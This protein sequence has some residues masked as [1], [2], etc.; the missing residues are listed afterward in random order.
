MGQ[1]SFDFLEREAH[2]AMIQAHL[3]AGNGC[4]CPPQSPGLPI[5]EVLDMMRK[6][7]ELARQTPKPKIAKGRAAAAKPKDEDTSRVVIEL[8]MRDGVSMFAVT[9][10]MVAEMKAGYPLVNI[11]EHLRFVKQKWTEDPDYRPAKLAYKALGVWM[12]RAQK[13]R[14][15]E[16]ARFATG[17]GSPPQSSDSARARQAM[18]DAQAERQREEDRAREAQRRS[19]NGG[20]AGSVIADLFGRKS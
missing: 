4:A 6:A 10:K 2:R 5:E 12:E 15:I 8:P 16:V 13:N 19:G 18:I 3:E 20:S 17:N 7:A 14:Q 11:V 9:E 1:D